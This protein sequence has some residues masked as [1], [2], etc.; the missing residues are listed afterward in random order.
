MTEANDVGCVKWCRMTEANETRIM[1]HQWKS[2]WDN[3]HSGNKWRMKLMGDN[4]L[5]EVHLWKWT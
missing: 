1:G 4:H 2:W 3:M 5:T